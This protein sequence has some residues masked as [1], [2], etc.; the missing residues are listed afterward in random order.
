[1]LATRVDSLAT[2][3]TW[4]LSGGGGWRRLRGLH[5]THWNI[6]YRGR[7]KLV[8]QSFK[9]QSP[10]PLPF[11]PSP[12]LTEHTTCANESTT[13]AWLQKATHSAKTILL[14]DYCTEI[15]TDGHA[16]LMFALFLNVFSLFLAL[17]FIAVTISRSVYN[18]VSR[19]AMP[20]CI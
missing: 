13:E 17:T 10:H 11:T 15:Y 18:V 7:R 5:R 3:A 2:A 4:K 9:K 8:P 12:L 14:Y 20:H 6:V 16:V 1:M 19:C